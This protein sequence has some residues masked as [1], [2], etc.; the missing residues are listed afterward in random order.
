M[1]GNEAIARGAYD[2]G[3]AVAAAYPGTPSTEIL[4]TLAI[5]PDIYAEWS[6]N[7][8]VALDVALGAALSGVRA[9]AAMK[10]VGLNVA[11]DPF[12]TA[13]YIGV[14]G[15]LVVVS[16]DDPGAH[17]SQNEQDNRHYARAAKAPLL[18]P[19]D[20]QEA[21]DFTREAFA[22]SERFNTPVLL[23]TTT[24][25]AHSRT[26]VQRLAEAEREPRRPAEFKHEISR[27]VAV[28]ACARARHPLV[29][30]R[31][32]AL[33][34]YASQCELNRIEWGD[35][36]L[37]IVSSGVAYQY[38]REVFPQA[39]FLKLGF[40]WPLPEKLVREFAAGVQRLVV[41]EELEPFLEDQIKALGLTCEGKSIFPIVGEFSVDS[42]A[43]QACLAGLA[44]QERETCPIPAVSAL[45]PRPPVLCPGCP[46]RSTY[47]VL[48]LLG[49]RQ[50]QSVGPELVIA[51]DIGCYTLG[52]LAPLKAMDTCVS[53]GSSIGVALGAAKAGVRQK[54][55][56][57]IG[58]STFMHSGFG[59]LLDVAYN[60]GDVTVIV[61]DNGT[62]AMTGHQEHPGTG[63]TAQGKPARRADIAA[64]ARAVGIEDVRKANAFE[65]AALRKQI[66]EAVETDGASVLVVEGL[67][68]L[69]NRGKYAPAR[70]AEDVC[71][72]CGV[73]L[74]LGCPAIV[75]NAAGRVAIDADTCMG[76]A[77]ALCVQ[78]C[79][80]KAI[81]IV[82]V[83]Q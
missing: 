13:S 66:R 45:P 27:L 24:R 77:C 35:R 6:P 79:P 57:V 48:S 78:V 52:S 8:K 11:A 29:E 39:S 51:G 63:R 58:D 5:C 34:E 20:S 36:S 23:R 65:F 74:R 33:A 81:S 7:E 37:G 25:I 47:Y 1:S 3:L 2:A 76:S 61:L 49:K 4:E 15:G 44:A 54:V 9:L 82:E 17:S 32:L 59:G 10:H 50:M 42:V 21:Y 43:H 73:C 70:V 46:H 67:C 83:G 26:A 18:E 60:G 30:Q 56:A 69:R 31:T 75:R 38:A 16:A 41:V 72:D 64:I 62:T 40:S 55:V 68:A 53:M 12:F 22:L 19:S 14:N 28:P 71:T 80:H